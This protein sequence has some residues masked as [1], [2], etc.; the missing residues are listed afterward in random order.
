MC[1]ATTVNALKTATFD[2]MFCR[3][4]RHTE[5][6]A[7]G[8]IALSHDLRNFK[9]AENVSSFVDPVTCVPEL[10]SKD[11]FRT[12]NL[13]SFLASS[14]AQELRIANDML[15]FRGS[16]PQSPYPVWTQK[17]MGWI[18]ES[19]RIKWKARV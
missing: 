13:R 4:A 7:K 18:L 6:R 9:G 8:L 17:I 15:G 2:I 19:C 16:T 3:V 1:G 14:A 5:C 12:E 11:Y 10:S